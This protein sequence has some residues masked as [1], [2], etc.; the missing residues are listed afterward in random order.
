M[1]LREIMTTKVHMV[2][3]ITPIQEAAEKMRTFD[4]GC[5]PVCDGDRLCGM[6]TDRDIIIR[7]VADSADVSKCCVRDAMTDGVVYLYEDQDVDEAARLMEMRAIRRL[8]ILDRGKHMVGIVT[9][10]DIAEHVSDFGISGRVL[11]RISE[12]PAQHVT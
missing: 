7:S 5:L 8:V 6:V 11:L 12:Q 2:T 10:G 9:L 4:V 3:P 1:L